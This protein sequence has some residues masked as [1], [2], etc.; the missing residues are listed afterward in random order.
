VEKGV[1]GV[2]VERY[3]ALPV[4]DLLY[5]VEKKNIFSLGSN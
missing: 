5:Q 3:E 2:V 1:Y 4:R